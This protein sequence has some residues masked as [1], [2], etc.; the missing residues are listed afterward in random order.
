MKER[1]ED[2]LYEKLVKKQ[3]KFFFAGKTKQY[4]FRIRQLTL[5][6]KAIREYETALYRAFELDLKKSEFEVYS[7]EIG[8]VLNSI[9]D[10]KKKLRRWMHP[11]KV[12]NPLFLTGS[13]SYVMLEPY[14]VMLIIGPF[15][16]PF[17]L[18]MEPLAGAIA[19]GNTAIIKPSEL[20][21]H[22]SAVIKEM[23][24]KYFKEEYICVVEGEVEETTRLLSQRFDFI[25]FT[26]SP[27][28]GK[29]VMEAA[30]KNL[31]PVILELGGKSPAIV[32]SDA[33]IKEAARKL[34]WGKF[35]NT[36]QTCV[37][38]DYVLADRKIKDTLVHE[39]KKAVFQFYGNEPQKSKDYGRLVSDRHW[40]RLKELMEKSAG[41]AVIGGETSAKERYIA[42]AVYDGITWEDSLMEE[43]IFG[44][45]LPVMTYDF[46]NFKQEVLVPI[47]ERDKP[48]ALYLFTRSNLLKKKI[49]RSLSFGGG[50][51]ND[52]VLHLSNTNLPF[53]GVGN[54]GIGSY[55]GIHGFKAFSH[56]KSIVEKSGLVNLSM[57]YPPY[58][59]KKLKMIK[60]VLR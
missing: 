60:K 14:G 18:I 20:T 32:T 13:K 45:V 7:T 29:I 11:E 38:P 40:Q 47:R 55:H 46:H 34:V 16:Y 39:M 22:V 4:D 28:V 52:T 37:A 48:L 56:E 30:A 27:R 49:L 8:F 59:L 10:T 17:Q 2:I 12:K 35:L 57:L 21:P 26:G 53:G 54:S 25:F 58:S 50:V 36:G 42:P 3:K 15:N 24:D 6:E 1:G 19:A 33:N 31:T 51:V 41:H 9:R 5:L 44:P 23:L 43:E